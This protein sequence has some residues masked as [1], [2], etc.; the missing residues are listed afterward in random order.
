[1]VEKIVITDENFY[2]LYSL[3]SSL[4]DNLNL[5]SSLFWMG[6]TIFYTKGN[7][8]FY[9]YPFDSL[10]QKVFTSDQ[11]NILLNGLFSDRIIYSAKT[12]SQK[13]EKL[14]NV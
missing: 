3:K 6:K 8:I 7:N 9:F 1:M 14:L 13:E 11:C 2:V 12:D 5:I 4:L 10:E